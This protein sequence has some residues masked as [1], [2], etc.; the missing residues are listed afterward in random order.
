[1]RGFCVL[2]KG[3]TFNLKFKP[4]KKQLLTLLFFIGA[5][6]CGSAQ[7]VSIPDTNF[8]YFLQTNFPNCMNGNL[9]DTTCYEVVN[10]TSMSC[11]NSQLYD[12][13]GIQYF[14]NLQ[15]L[16]C[17]GNHLDSLPLL[18]NS[19]TELF[20]RDNLLSSLPILSD[21]MTRLDCSLNQFA[22]LPSL[23]SSL[24]ELDCG[25]NQITSLPSLPSSLTSLLCYNSFLT[26][27]PSLPNSITT[28]YCEG[29]YLSSLPTLPTSLDL[30]WCDQNLLNNLPALPGSLTYLS[31]GS[32]LLTSIPQLPDSVYMLNCQH[33]P[34][35]YCLPRLKKIGT[36]YISYT[37]ITCLPNSP[38]VTTIIDVPLDSLSIC[39]STN[40]HG[41]SYCHAYFSLFPDTANP[42]IYNGYNL[43]YGSNLTSYLWEFGDG[44]TSTLQYPSHTYAQ[45]GQYYICLTASGADCTNTYCDSSY[46]VFKTENGLMS[47]VNILNPTTTAIQPTNSLKGEPLRINPNPASSSVNVSVNETMLGNA[48][49]VYDITGRKMAAVQL[50]TA[51]TKLETSSFT[52]GVYFVTVENEKGRV[53]KK[54]VIEK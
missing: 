19:L 44:T 46:L 31:C 1:M 36:L 12:L 30:L 14:D 17:S 3:V 9:M 20:C 47:Q 28:I 5:W 39:D 2:G 6:F 38:Q 51:N 7:W 22:I 45:A 34:N 40:I 53:T 16:D 37:G 27:L 52:S 24:K 32:N 23:P 43:S 11:F 49:T 50:K 26:S 48:A 42:G 15:F 10:T 18:P 13:T 54:L 8:V 35:L 41:C 25:N 4:M 33:N 21:S 29:N